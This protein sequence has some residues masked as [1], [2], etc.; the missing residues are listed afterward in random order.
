MKQIPFIDLF[1][2]DF[3]FIDIA[4]DRYASGSVIRGGYS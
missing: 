2:I 1:F 4:T 3:Y